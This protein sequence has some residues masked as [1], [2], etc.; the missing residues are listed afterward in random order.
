MH[1][2]FRYKGVQPHV[3]NLQNK[4]NLTLDQFQIGRRWNCHRTTVLRICMRYGY[5]GL[6]FGGRASARRFALLEIV[7]IEKLARFSK[8]GTKQ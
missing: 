2:S 8:G 4:E 1:L 7:K 5:S 3:P 6:K